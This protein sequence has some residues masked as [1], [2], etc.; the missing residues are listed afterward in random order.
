MKTSCAFMATVFHVPP[1]S[2]L[3][4]SDEPVAARIAPSVTP[5]TD[6][7]GLGLGISVHASEAVAN[8]RAPVAPIETVRRT[9]P[10]IPDM[11]HASCKTEC[12]NVSAY[13]L[14]PTPAATMVTRMLRLCVHVGAAVRCCVHT[15]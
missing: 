4:S 9:F 1:R 13:L 3:I 6:I 10:P 11:V 15:C 5:P 14:N 2:L 12:A 7:D 8:T